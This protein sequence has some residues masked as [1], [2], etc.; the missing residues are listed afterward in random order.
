MVQR[1]VMLGGWLLTGYITW[2][3]PDETFLSYYVVYFT[4]LPNMTDEDGDT[5]GVPGGEG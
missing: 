5:W 2:N 3:R 1:N 4:E